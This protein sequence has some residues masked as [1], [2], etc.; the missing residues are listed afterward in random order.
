[1]RVKAHIA[2]GDV[3][4]ANLTQQFAAPFDADPWKLY[5]A[6]AKSS[7][8]PRSAYLEVPGLALVSASPEMFVDVDRDGAAETRPIKGTRP[9]GDTPMADAQAAEELL[10]YAKDRFTGES[11]QSSDVVL[12]QQYKAEKPSTFLNIPATVTYGLD[13]KKLAA[14]KEAK[15]TRTADQKAVVLADQKD[16]GILSHHLSQVRWCGRA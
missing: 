11:L 5:R 3:Y 6:I 13:G 8:A 15:D 7:P 12:Y 1:M 4:Q 14:A 16:A 2:R 9:R 10:G